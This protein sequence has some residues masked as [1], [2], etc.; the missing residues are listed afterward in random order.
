MEVLFGI[1][2]FVLA[3]F[4]V[5]WR[6]FGG[7]I[8]HKIAEKESEK[9]LDCDACRTKLENTE[10]H[11][12]LIPVYFDHGHENSAQYYA[13]N[14]RPIADRELIPSGQRA[15][16]MHIFTCPTCGSK[17]VSVVDFLRVRDQ[18]L[19]KGGGVFPYG[20]FG[21]FFEK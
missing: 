4:V 15:C 18:D 6:L 9:G 7:S 16:W 20:D 21:R 5:V 3:A 12:Y 14:A 19:P 1:L 2:G 13:A 11:L 17:K 10:S 8:L